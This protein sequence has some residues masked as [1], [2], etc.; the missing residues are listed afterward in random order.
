MGEFENA[1]YQPKPIARF[2]NAKSTV[3]SMVC[4]FEENSF[5]NP[6]SL[7]WRPSS[8]GEEIFLGAPGLPLLSGRPRIF[9][10]S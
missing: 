8:G 3:A 1:K 10:L 6:A 5:Q 2:Q 9:D 7:I 4:G